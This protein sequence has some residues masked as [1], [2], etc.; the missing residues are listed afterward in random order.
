MDPGKL[1]VDGRLTGF[2]VYCGGAPST[3]DHVPSKILLDDPY[4]P[5]L[6][7]V[8]ACN[9]CNAS[10]SKDEQYVAC[11]IAC[12][13]SGSA[14]PDGIRRERIRRTL[15]SNPALANR[16]GESRRAIGE[17]EIS[18]D[19]ESN[20]VRNVVLKLAR[21]HTAYEVSVPQLEEPISIGFVPL[22]AITYR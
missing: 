15:A 9:S 3:R 10:F 17:G 14:D 21:G 19:V 18:W 11:L 1:F 2:C 6:P 4:P 13:L 16:I 20:R 22:V 12:V 8:A 5:Q 7:V